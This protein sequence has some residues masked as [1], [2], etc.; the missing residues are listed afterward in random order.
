MNT[1]D[2][3]AL[4]QHILL[5]EAEAQSRL[6]NGMNP[7]VIRQSLGPFTS[8]DAGGSERVKAAIDAYLQS[9]VKTDLPEFMRTFWGGAE[10]ASIIGSLLADIRNTTMHS[11]AVS[12]AATI[13][14][15]EMIRGIAERMGFNA[16]GIFTTGGSNGNE[17]GLLC[18]R[19]NLIPGSHRTGIQGH[20]LCVLTSD[21][22]HY[23]VDSAV[24]RMGIGID[25][26]IRVPTNDG[27]MQSPH[28]IEAIQRVKGEGM[29]PLAIVSTAGSTV[30]GAFE[31]LNAIA[32]I[33]EEH[34]IWHHVDAAWGGP[35]IFSSRYRNMLDGIER[36]DSVTFDAHKML[37]ASMVCSMFLIRDEQILE[38][39]MAH[40]KKGDYLF[41]DPVSSQSLGRISPQCGRRADALKLWLTW[42]DIGSEGFGLRVDHCMDV[43]EYIANLAQSL[44]EVELISHQFTNVCIRFTPKEDETPEEGD[45]RVRKARNKLEQDGTAMVIDSVLDGRLVIRFAAAHPS[46]T[47]DSVEEFL[48]NLVNADRT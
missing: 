47:K 25:S 38:N 19:E 35:V 9:A 11:F 40:T 29:E 46:I 10:P 6:H 28:L 15:R 8:E 31:D 33:A 24:N 14:E 26:I 12:P 4:I 44:D 42:L 45:S 34:G 13:I 22:S 5:S 36:A 48:S 37:G 43:A 41:D 39:S 7:Q 3:D 20:R 21:E 16:N 18:A 2:R 27:V 30:R 1:H 17:L 23:S 32:D